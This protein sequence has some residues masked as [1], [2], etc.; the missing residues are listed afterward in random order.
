MEMHTFGLVWLVQLHVLFP[1]KMTLKE[2][3]HIIVF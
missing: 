1:I 3:L 2:I